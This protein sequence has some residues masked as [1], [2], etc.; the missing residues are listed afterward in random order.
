MGKN[1]D[2]T[3]SP[4]S[5]HL[6]QLRW[7]TVPSARTNAPC[8]EF[9]QAEHGDDER[10]AEVVEDVDVNGPPALFGALDEE[11]SEWVDNWEATLLRR[12]LSERVSDVGVRLGLLGVGGRLA[13][14]K[15]GEGCGREPGVPFRSCLLR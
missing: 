3:T 10:L 4:Q 1:F 2:A 12:G 8:I 15:P 14:R 7:K 5:K 9:P 13:E 11:E 6:K